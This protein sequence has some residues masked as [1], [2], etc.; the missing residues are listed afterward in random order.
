M[1]ISLKGNVVII[2]EAHNLLDT[3]SNIHSAQITG[4]QVLSVLSQLK[5][6]GMVCG[7]RLS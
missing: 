6:E 7:L 3:I 4:T 5:L 1:G 2:D